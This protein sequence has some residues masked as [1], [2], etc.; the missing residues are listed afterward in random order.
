MPNFMI[1]STITTKLWWGPSWP[2]P[3]D[4]R[5]KKSPCQIGLKQHGLPDY[6][7]HISRSSHLCLSVM[8]Y[9]Q[10]IVFI[11]QQIMLSWQSI[12]VHN[13]HNM[14]ITWLI[15]HFFKLQVQILYG[16]ENTSSFNI[17]KLWL[18]TSFSA[19][20]ASYYR[21]FPKISELWRFPFGDALTQL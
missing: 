14:R 7:T 13:F 3:H 9:E 5:F 1:I 17:L 20:R 6:L 4:W 10:F 21:R 19:K 11:V 15:Y 16:L 18:V 8:I 12:L 2:H